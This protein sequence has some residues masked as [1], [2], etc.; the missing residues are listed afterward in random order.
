MFVDQVGQLVGRS[1]CGPKCYNWCC[2][3][4]VWQ[5][6]VPS[7]FNQSCEFLSAI[8]YDEVRV[9]FV[10]VAAALGIVILCAKSVVVV[11]MSWPRKGEASV[12]GCKD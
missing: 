9:S 10:R 12:G 7:T 1:P 6:R 8:K 4:D 5:Q 3:F 2:E 11:T